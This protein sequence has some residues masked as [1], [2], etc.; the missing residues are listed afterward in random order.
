MSTLQGRRQ[1]SLRTYDPEKYLPAFRATKFSLRTERPLGP[2]NSHAHGFRVRRA[3]GKTTSGRF[4]CALDGARPASVRGQLQPNA[5]QHIIPARTIPSTATFLPNIV[6]QIATRVICGRE[7]R[8][9][10]EG[11]FATERRSAKPSLRDRGKN[12]L[13]SKSSLAAAY[14][15]RRS[16]KQ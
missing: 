5:G 1:C 13:G 3:Q 11:V 10:A 12:S 8:F 4:S 16:E 2:V 9:A 7:G 14:Y 15:S 6:Q